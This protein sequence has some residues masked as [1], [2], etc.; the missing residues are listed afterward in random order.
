[1]KKEFGVVS[2]LVPLGYKILSKWFDSS[3]GAIQWL[4]HMFEN[5]CFY[6]GGCTCQGYTTWNDTLQEWRNTHSQEEF[7]KMFEEY[8]KVLKEAN[9]KKH[10]SN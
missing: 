7:E 9:E 5:E 1:M 6:F 3:E 4:N 8:D 2:L 10:N